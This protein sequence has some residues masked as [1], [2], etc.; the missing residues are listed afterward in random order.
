MKKLLVHT[1]LKNKINTE[2]VL[3]NLTLNQNNIN[4][5]KGL[6]VSELINLRVK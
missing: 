1:R 6:A 4:R 5:M 3:R 2:L